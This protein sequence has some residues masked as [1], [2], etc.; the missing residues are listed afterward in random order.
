MPLVAVCPKGTT[1]FACEPLLDTRVDYQVGTN[2]NAVCS[3]DFDD[4][5]RLNLAEA[6]QGSVSIS[7]L[8]SNGNGAFDGAEF[9]VNCE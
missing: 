8:K 3:A 6:I 2:P 1:T 9:R 4:D 5:G 7:T